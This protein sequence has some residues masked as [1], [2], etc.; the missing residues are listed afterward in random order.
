MFNNIN[1][2]V[3][4]Y[5]LVYDIRIR[6]TFNVVHTLHFKL[7]NGFLMLL[8]SRRIPHI[9]GQNPYIPYFPPSSGGSAC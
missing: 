7:D 3:K 6:S 1:Y 2:E 9:L 8:A 5:I 4:S